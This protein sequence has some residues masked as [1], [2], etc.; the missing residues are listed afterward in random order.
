M[1]AK[2]LVIGATLFLTS[3]LGTQ[4]QTVTREMARPTVTVPPLITFGGVLKARNG[5]PPTGVVGLTFSLYKDQEGGV[6]IWTE[7]QNVQ[8]DAEG[9]YTTLLGATQASGLPMDVFASGQSRWLGVQPQL[10]GEGEQPRVLLVSVPYALKAADADTIGGK[11]VSAFVLAESET[12]LGA[13]RS[14]D[15]SINTLLPNTQRFASTFG[16]IQDNGTG[17]SMTIT[18][19]DNIGIGTT[20]P[21]A[22][23]E[24]DGG[25]EL[26][27]LNGT[28]NTM[29]SFM[30]SQAGSKN[31]AFL[32][33]QYGKFYIY[34][35]TDSVPELVANSSHYIGIGTPNPVSPLHIFSSGPAFGL[36]EGTSPGIDVG[37]SVK[38]DASGKLWSIRSS[39]SGQLM[40]RDDS[41]GIAR[42]TLDSSGKVGIG[43]SAPG[44]NLDVQGGQINA[45]GGLCINGTCQTSWPAGT[46]TGVTAGTGL[47]GGGAT[48]SVAL[49]VANGGIGTAQLAAAAK[50]RSITYL[51]GCDSCSALASTDSQHMIYINLLGSMTIN[52][53]SCYS[54]AGSPVINIARNSTNILGSSGTTAANLTCLPGGASSGIL[55]AQNTLSLNDTMDFVMVTPDG[56]A[57]RAT[58]VI[59]ATLN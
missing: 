12:R 46:I 25:A 35:L 7:N 30:T 14:L 4:G 43:T 8:V 26:L 28:G 27:R 11:P 20:T 37:W 55:T 40:F 1:R 5:Q 34:N 10:P 59:L 42:F 6:P 49:S 3:I 36:V 17:T 29:L 24:V 41:L 16:S 32:L 38:N 18:S 33:D 52:S 15:E 9:R 45:S 44:Y 47:T 57:K 56:V 2:L 13:P 39:A 58:V 51:A 22:P 31:R 19:S 48:G 53:V 23:L 50:T 54:D 21:A